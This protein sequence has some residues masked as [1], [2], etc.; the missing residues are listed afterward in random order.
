MPE[1]GEVKPRG[2]A[3]QPS[4]DFKARETARAVY[5]NA[6]TRLVLLAP[7][8]AAFET[9][10]TIADVHAATALFVAIVF[11]ADLAYGACADMRIGVPPDEE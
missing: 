9:L 11:H 3:F 6:W 1:P 10:D 8:V 5:D 7:A 4:A 2:K